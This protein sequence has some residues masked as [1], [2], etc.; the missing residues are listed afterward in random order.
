MIVQQVISRL[1]WHLKTKK[2]IFS[3]LFSFVLVKRIMFVSNI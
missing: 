3:D 1:L 2:M